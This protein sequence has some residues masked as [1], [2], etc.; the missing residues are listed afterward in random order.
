MP[1]DGGHLVA[2]GGRAA[3]A[4]GLSLLAVAELPPCCACAGVR[5]APLVGRCD[6]SELYKRLSC[7][8]GVVL[9]CLFTL[10]RLSG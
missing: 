7:G 2:G 1:A 5:M 3:F 9:L 6:L 10:C 8:P 4:F